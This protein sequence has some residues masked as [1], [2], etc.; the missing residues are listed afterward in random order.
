MN[1]LVR[2][3][4]LRSD[5]K[6]LF[7]SSS[8]PSVVPVPS[9][10]S[11]TFGLVTAAL[12]SAISTKLLL[13]FVAKYHNRPYPFTPVFAFARVMDFCTAC[14]GNEQYDRPITRSV[15]LFLMRGK[16]NQGHKF[17]TLLSIQST[18][19]VTYNRKSPGK[20]IEHNRTHL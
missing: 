7:R 12:A 10:F 18:K 4:H 6:V 1:H 3:A 17:W 2:R 14:V 16:F 15:I 8:F 19:A 9:A 20:A 13:K 5:L 11:K